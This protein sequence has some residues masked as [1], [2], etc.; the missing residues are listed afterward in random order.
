MSSTFG[1]PVRGTKNNFF[2]SPG[3][4]TKLGGSTV[5][6]AKGRPTTASPVKQMSPPRKPGE[7]SGYGPSPKKRPGT[8][9]TNSKKKQPKELKDLVKKK[10]RLTHDE[11]IA[12]LHDLLECAK[13]IQDPLDD[14]ETIFNK[15]LAWKE[16]Q[17]DLD[18][19]EKA[20]THALKQDAN[21]KVDVHNV[22]TLAQKL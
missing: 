15:I 20:V 4:S 17:G 5:K 8:A 19:Q 16:K 7:S 6:Q 11:V 12:Y 22:R 18:Q 14:I 2:N 13:R 1:S 21:N 3:K 9:A 10:D